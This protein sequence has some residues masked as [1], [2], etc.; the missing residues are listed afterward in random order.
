MLRVSEQDTQKAFTRRVVV[1]AAAKFALVSALIGR[2]YY[3]QVVEAKKYV[4]LSRDNQFNLELLPP[5]RGRIFDRNGEPLA[6]NRDNFRIE[7][8]SERTD[9]VPRTLRALSSIINIPEYEARR[10]MREVKRKRAFVPI[11]VVE[12]LSR[13]E[14]SRVAAN[15]PY[16][17]GVNIEVGRSRHYP[18]GDLTAH[19][20]GYVAAVSESELNGDPVLELPDFRIGKSG[21]EKLRDQDMRGT[22][23]RRQVEVNA[24]G[25]IIRKLPGK[26]GQPGQDIEVSID[27]ELQKFAYE[28]L[29]IGSSKKVSIDDP[30]VLKALAGLDPE[31]ADEYRSAGEVLLD[32]KGR[33][34]PGESGSVVVMDVHNGDVL[35]LASTPAYDPNKFNQGLSA[36]DWED[37]L[38]NPRAPLTNKAIA[39]QFS[40]GSTYKMLVALAAMEAG[41]YSP[42]F[43][44]FCGGH[45]DLG[46]TRFHC[47]KRHGHGWLD[48]AQA[49]EQS[50]DV[51]MYEIAKKVGIDRIS[52]MSRRLGLGEKLGLEIP[53]ERRGLVPSR[54]WKLATQGVPWQVGETL[55]TGIGQGYVLT[56]PLQLATMTSRLVNG[57]RAVNPRIILPAA[58]NPD[59]EY[60]SLGLR[61]ENLT[62]MLNAM[63]DVMNGER[64]TARGSKVKGEDWKMGGKT[65]TVQVKRITLAERQA[66]IVKNEDRPWR[67]RD[68]AIFVGF[69]PVEAPRYAVAVVV[70][71][72]GGG[73]STAAPIARDVMIETMRR[74]PSRAKIKTTAAP[75]DSKT[76]K[77]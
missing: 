2:L 13:M 53:G 23:G 51:Y 45:V 69:A 27:V 75:A 63:S 62:S 46:D 54:E 41:I 20:T 64:G 12:N 32:G 68:H 1:L 39:G 59:P 3:L 37:L 48:M 73:S 17:P 47:W 11:T 71:H 28:R 24:L 10:V 25:R 16:L 56:T 58:D 31:T 33:I 15:A 44:V 49:I 26:E 7:V 77:S 66:G 52:A 22:A 18:Y 19:V 9:D 34:V 4:T 40:P 36:R 6:E 42:D 61:A 55:I 72:G 5:I 76:G 35:A 14:I 8:V 38:S 43:K 74:D 60:P 70:E 57:G 50:C 30:L 29:A 21:I 65:G 67:D